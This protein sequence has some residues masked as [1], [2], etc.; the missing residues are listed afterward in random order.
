[1]YPIENRESQEFLKPEKYETLGL[2]DEGILK[3]YTSAAEIKD[4]FKNFLDKNMH[5]T[6]FYKDTCTYKM[7]MPYGRKLEIEIKIE[8]KDSIPKQI[9]L[10]DLLFYYKFESAKFIKLKSGFKEYL[11]AEYRR[12][13]KNLKEKYLIK[14]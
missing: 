12:E 10:K 13:L 3:R 5:Y 2:F 4:S 9:V 8:Y 6:K 11:E 1:M 14:E 7:F